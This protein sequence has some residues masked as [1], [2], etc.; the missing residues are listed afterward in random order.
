[1]KQSWNQKVFIYHSHYPASLTPLV[2]ISSS[3]KCLKIS[4]TIYV[5]FILPDVYQFIVYFP[6][7]VSP[8]RLFSISP[9]FH[10][11]SSPA[12]ILSCG[13][14]LLALVLLIPEAC[15]L[16]VDAVACKMFQT[17]PEKRQASADF[18]HM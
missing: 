12:F 14:S 11:L 1:M 4:A 8:L 2:A 6:F 18:M 3:P 5:T 10:V 15:G 16:P 13:R 9:S 7:S 17:C